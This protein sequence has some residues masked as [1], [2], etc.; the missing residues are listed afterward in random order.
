MKRCLLLL[1]AVWLM[2]GFAMLHDLTAGG[3]V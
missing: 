1:A 3:V 2:L